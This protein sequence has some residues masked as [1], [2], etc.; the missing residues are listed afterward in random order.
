MTAAIRISILLF[1]YR[2]FVTPGSRPH[3]HLNWVLKV[4]VIL[5]II[6]LVV[7]SILP[8][9]ICR[10]LY[11]A[12]HPLERQLY[13]N[14]WYYYHIQVALYSTSMTFDMILLFLP[15][16]PVWQLQMPLKS[17]ASVSLIFMLGAAWV[18]LRP[19]HRLSEY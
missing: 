13:F 11:M 9:F 5:Q 19:L 6:Y 8:G 14:D 15:V 10:P 1:Y 3:S 17:R 16:H 2:I 7:Y 4:L 18:P 12:W